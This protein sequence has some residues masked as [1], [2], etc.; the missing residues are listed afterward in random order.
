MRIT[1]S[2]KTSLFV[3]WLLQNLI[4]TITMKKIYSVL[5]MK[6]LQVTWE[7]ITLDLDNCKN[8]PDFQRVTFVS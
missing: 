1:L 5:K 4:I 3:I 6:H 8:Q 2:S 7:E